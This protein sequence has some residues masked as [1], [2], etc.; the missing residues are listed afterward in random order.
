MPAIYNY[1]KQREIKCCGCG[2]KGVHFINCPNCQ[3]KGLLEKI[4]EFVLSL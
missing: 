3:E 1:K 2:K 4:K